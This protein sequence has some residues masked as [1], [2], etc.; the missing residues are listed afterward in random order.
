MTNITQRAVAQNKVQAPK[1]KFAVNTAGKNK[2]WDFEQLAT[3]FKDAEG[4]IYEVAQHVLN[5]HALCAGVL[6]NRRRSK[7]NVVGSHWVLVDVDNSDAKRDEKGNPV[8]GE[9]VYKHQMTLEEAIENPFV[10]QYCSLVYTTSSHKP[11]WHKFRLIFLLPQFV[12]G[13]DVVE[14]AIRLLL[15][16]FPHDPAC[17]DSSRV[18]YGSS[19]A[20]IP[21]LNPD[22]TLPSD[23]IERAKQGA[24]AQ[25]I[26]TE[27][28]LQ[29]IGENREKY[30]QLA[31]SEGWDTD[32]LIEQALS[33][34]PPRSPGSNNYQE[35]T[36]VLMALVNHY[37]A[38]QAEVIGERWSPSIK[39][40][41][42][43]VGK[44]IRS[45]K[46]REG[47]SIGSLFHIAKQ[48]GF[49]FPA[50]KMPTGRSIGSSN[51]R[52][53]KGGSSGGDDNPPTAETIR[54]RVREIVERS[55][56]DFDRRVA[57]NTLSQE[58]GISIREIEKLAEAL[59]AEVE[60][61]DSRS[62][63]QQEVEQLLKL[64][65]GTLNLFDYLPNCL[66][67][68]LTA[69]ASWL[70]L[71]PEAVLLSLLTATSSLH[72]V[73]T[74]LVLHKTQG[75]SVPPIIF[76]AVVAESGQKKSPLT[77]QIVSKPI[78][79]LHQEAKERHKKELAA[80]D[81]EMKEW[82]P[83]HGDKP[84]KPIQEVFYFTNATGEGIQKQASQCPDKSL[85]ALVDEL[86]GFFN[87]QNQYRGGRGSDK[88]DMLSYFD[89]WGT[90]SLRA[91]GVT[92]D[93]QHIYLSV[94]GTIQPEVIKSIMGDSSDP[95]GS[96]ARFLFAHQ[97]LVASTLPDDDGSGI[98]IVERL[99]SVY[100][101]L[102][103]V[104][105]QQYI[106]SREAFKVYQPYYNKLEQLRVSHHQPG[107]RAVYSKAEG[108][109][110][111]LALNLHVLN[112]L[113]SGYHTPCLEIP[114]ETMKKAI[115]LMNFFVG[116][117][118]L[119]YSAFDEG[120]APH[121]AKL[122]ELSKNREATTGDGWIKAKDVQLSINKKSRPTPDTV[123]SWMREAEALG[124]GSTRGIGRNAE[125]LAKV[126]K[127]DE[128]R[129]KVDPPSTFSNNEIS[130]VSSVNNPKVD[131]VDQNP[132]LPNATE[133]NLLEVV[134]NNLSL[135]VDTKVDT[136]P[137]TVYQSDSNVDT[138]S[139]TKVDPPST[140]GSTFEK[141]ST[142]VDEE[143]DSE[144]FNPVA[145]ANLM[146][147][148][149]EANA[150][151]SLLKLVDEL[152][153]EQKAEVRKHLT[154]EQYRDVRRLLVDAR[155]QNS[156]TQKE[157]APVQ[158]EKI[159]VGARVK[160]VESEDKRCGECGEVTQTSGRSCKV[161]LDSDKSVILYHFDELEVRQ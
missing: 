32:A 65:Q 6:N 25:K 103:Q 97:P 108:Y 161:I 137:S 36:Q 114:A 92:N 127:V 7:S 1:I 47:V 23:W 74:E 76:G 110:G 88:Q 38:V 40:D 78:Q 94:F 160:V 11:D 10:K 4:T 79:K 102:Y 109:T 96:W 71:R 154:P 29:E 3:Q 159:K 120:L 37:G 17:K 107:M 67:E 27:K 123:R 53:I 57:L 125:F 83:E 148:H 105:Q 150:G 30:Q 118:K 54:A 46:R 135:K 147:S 77:R 157:S 84:E 44:K 69:Y 119:L 146:V 116:Q 141:R 81:A 82:K 155:N 19:N 80:Y 26:E 99:A 90:V 49:R 59:L 101:R 21:L 129:P 121:I 91:S 50:P 68:A 51:L 34:I 139:D 98:N 18:F 31:T 70:N 115:K 61:G 8:K 113:T 93:A 5:G 60:L 145:N 138:A 144:Q 142:L 52:L 153:P 134:Q 56:T 140:F 133:S 12:E 33:Y 45:Y 58:T 156:D 112:E 143:L 72:K 24:E 35:C 100:R 122:I 152:T 42:W 62:D 64:G 158:T 111:R 87:S 73:G 86:A 55:G 63:H 41:T 13:A 9:K 22:V 117:T 16:Q 66:A 132:H 136:P 124:F 131:K 89:G 75:F 2:H 43:D 95:D 39:G 104:P 126:D 130:I 151:D 106:L 28:R 128:S 15:E 20:Q 149:L 48:Y 85:L 14:Q